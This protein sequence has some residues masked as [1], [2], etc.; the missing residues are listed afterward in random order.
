MD[1]IP[2]HKWV[3]VTDPSLTFPFQGLWEQE[4]Y[5]DSIY[6]LPICVAS[7]PLLGL[8]ILAN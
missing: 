2:G 8:Y 3:P 1:N 4:M 6:L 5:S 7:F